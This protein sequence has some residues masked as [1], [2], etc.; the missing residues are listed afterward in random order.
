MKY[1]HFPRT[2]IPVSEISLG[3][4][5]LVSVG[6]KIT[7]DVIGAAIEHG[8]NYVDVV[9]PQPDL[10]DWIGAALRGRREKMMVAGH[11]RC[12]VENR[13]TSR[14]LNVA[15]S[16]KH[17][18]DLLRRLKTDYVDMLHLYCV[19]SP[20]DADACLDEKG[21]LGVA[22]RLL[23]EGKA[24]MLGF[25]GHVPAVASRLVATG[26]FDGMMFSI[27][28]AMD[29]M[30]SDAT[31]DDLHNGT[32]AFMNK[33]AGCH[34]DRLALYRQCEVA[35][36]GIIVMK[37]YYAG[38]LLKQPGMTPEKCIHYALTRPG[39][40][41]MA[42]GCR[43]VAEVEA[44]TRYCT[45]TN[46]ERDFAEVIRNTQWNS[47]G[48][49]MYCNHCQ[50]C[51]SALDVAAIT[52]LLHRFTEGDA[53]AKAEYAGL[54]PNGADCTECGACETRCPFGVDSPGNV[55]RAHRLMGG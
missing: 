30:L 33:P 8:M 47:T 24:R 52:R 23:K 32:D 17:I 7:A 25:S 27:N 51:P 50:P 44:A 39:V 4:E 5:H 21:L 9:M 18:E 31:I 53:R 45:A 38:F 37:G 13:Q 11:L 22:Q 36:T 49:C 12:I 1:R 35:R 2:G 48:V 42:A 43:S 40:V 55:T 10:R 26:L 3:A 54:T 15:A 6:P 20:E 14:T 28:P 41:T 19:D 34:S 29:L 46:E 16:V